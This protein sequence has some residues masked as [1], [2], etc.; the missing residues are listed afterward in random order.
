[1]NAALKILIGLVI[2]ATGFGFFID[3]PSVGL[4]NSATGINWWNNFLIVVTGTIPALLVL[5]GIFIVWL[6]GDELSAE[7]EMKAEE[8]TMETKEVKTAVTASKSPGTPAKRRGRPK[9]RK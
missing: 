8:E 6:E 5:I 4:W 9:R 7:K 3:S 1:M 2:I